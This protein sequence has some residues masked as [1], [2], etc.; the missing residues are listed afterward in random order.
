M[1]R[2]GFVCRYRLA[3]ADNHSD[4]A[5][6][7]ASAS[8]ARLDG[9]HHHIPLVQDV[10]LDTVGHTNRCAGLWSPSGLPQ[11]MEHGFRLAVGCCDWPFPLACHPAY[12]S[13]Y[14]SARLVDTVPADTMPGDMVPGDTT[15]GD[16][17]L[18]DVAPVD[19][20]PVDVTSGD[21]VPGY[22]T[23]GDAIPV[24]TVLV[25]AMLVDTMLVDAVPAN[26]MLVMNRAPGVRER[27][28][29]PHVSTTDEHNHH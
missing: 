14:A 3:L 24:D 11:D 17:V 21:T 2:I 23:P 20:M 19:V 28:I 16:T 8:D 25:D 27:P 13:L 29:V 1:L 26:V 7:A 6:Q 4:P 15:P 18:V 22:T 9:F 5:P 10:C 12:H